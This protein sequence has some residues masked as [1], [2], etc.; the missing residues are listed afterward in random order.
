MENGIKKNH[1]SGQGRTGDLEQ[2]PKKS[3]SG[4]PKGDFQ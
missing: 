2:G 4:K 1:P 3:P